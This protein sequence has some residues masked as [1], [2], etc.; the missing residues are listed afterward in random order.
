MR[1][2]SATQV[3]FL[4]DCGF[5][6]VWLPWDGRSSTGRWWPCSGWSQT[7]WDACPAVAAPTRSSTQLKL[8]QSFNVT[9]CAQLYSL[10]E[11]PQLLL[12]P[13]IWT[14]ITRALLVSKV[15]R[16]LFETPW[17]PSS[18]ADKVFKENQMCNKKPCKLTKYVY[19][20]AKTWQNLWFS[21]LIYLFFW[22]F[23]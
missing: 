17:S 6:F 13:R 21:I 23:C 14:R 2:R 16:H 7:G 11:T 15:R 5:C 3:K 18:V 12:S 9:W 22:P 8:N 1:I 4:Y 19:N 10:A 20:W